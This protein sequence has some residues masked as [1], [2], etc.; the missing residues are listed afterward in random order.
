ML[1][2]HLFI[3][4]IDSE[5]T[6]PNFSI[7]RVQVGHSFILNCS[8][9]ASVPAVTVQWLK[10]TTDV[11]TLPTNNNRFYIYST[12]TTSS[13]I[14]SHFMNVDADTY[15]CRISN[16]LVPAITYTQII[17]SVTRGVC[18]LCVY[19]CVCVCVYTGTV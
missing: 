14:V 7:L 10:D 19:V 13:L 6:A 17:N 18:V 15:S 16:D 5:P 8:L 3:I 1:S 2:T 11:L 9:P 4:D 12:E